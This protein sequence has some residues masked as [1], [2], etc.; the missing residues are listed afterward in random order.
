MT[1][2]IAMFGDSWGCGEWTSVKKYN[3]LSKSKHQVSHKGLEQYFEE[4][5]YV[6]TNHCKPAS[7]NVINIGSFVDHFSISQPPTTNFFIVTDPTRNLQPDYTKFKQYLIDANGLF[8]L[9]STL[10]KNDLDR[11]NRHAVELNQTVYLIGGLFTVPAESYWSNLTCLCES[12]PK[13]LVG[14]SYPDTDFDNF[15]RWEAWIIDG[16]VINKWITAD[17][18]ATLP[19]GLGSKLLLE[20]T[21]LDANGKVFAHDY[22][23]PDGA[24]PNREGHK[25]MFDL[26]C[27]QL[28]L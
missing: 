11:L 7:S 6:V 16:Q 12:W 4:A 23:I 18:L 9:K 27:K 2:Q 19:N 13:L 28:H 25:I 26:I 3:I 1:R 17:N 24:H 21:N 8:N 22:F 5:G 20:L 14:E 15:G 10:L